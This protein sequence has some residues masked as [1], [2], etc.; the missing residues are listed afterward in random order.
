MNLSKS[1][2]GAV[3][4]VAVL[5]AVVGGLVLLGP[6]AEERARRLDER[7][8]EDLRRISDATNVYWTRH[9]RLP[10][11]L[12]E[13]SAQPGTS[14]VSRDPET[15]EPYG[16]QRLGGEIYELCAAFERDSSSDGQVRGTG[17]FWSHGSGRYCFQ[18]KVRTIRQ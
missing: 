3:A 11:S 10:E 5:A 7:R 6:P 15:G 8:V 18:L 13:L 4:V 2:I 12:E 1:A 14:I 16:F 17:D 9:M